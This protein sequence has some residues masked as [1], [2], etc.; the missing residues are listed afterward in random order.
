MIR[1][2]LAERVGVLDRRSFE[3]FE[4]VA[5]VNATDLGE[6]FIEA[7]ELCSLDVA[8]TLRD[9]CSRARGCIALGHE[10][11][12]GP[13]AKEKLP[14]HPRGATGEPALYRIGPWRESRG[15]GRS[16]RCVNRLP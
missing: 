9:T 2:K 13:V 11:E 1:Q 7:A 5:L 12:R 16:L 8:K 3:R 10:G 15:Q 14:R 4:A 6:H